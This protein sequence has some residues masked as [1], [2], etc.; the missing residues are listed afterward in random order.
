MVGCLTFAIVMPECSFNTNNL[1]Q[2][3][4]NDNGPVMGSCIWHHGT[5]NTLNTGCVPEQTN[6]EQAPSNSS[7]SV[8]FTRCSLMIPPQIMLHN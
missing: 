8:I 1:T 3:K 2:Q 7:N 4:N 5:W 6:M